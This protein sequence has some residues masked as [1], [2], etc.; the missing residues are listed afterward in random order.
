MESVVPRG[1]LICDLA[2]TRQERHLPSLLDW[3]VWQHLNIGITNHN[4]KAVLS[5]GL[6][7]DPRENKQTVV[8]NRSLNGALT[9]APTI[10]RTFFQ[11]YLKEQEVPGS[12]VDTLVRGSM[13]H[14]LD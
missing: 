12:V 9:T 3:Q 14:G 1:N 5:L 6:N 10:A 11:V 8:T 2:L 4:F 7:P 13:V